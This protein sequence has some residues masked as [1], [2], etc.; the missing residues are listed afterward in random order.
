MG[1]DANIDPPNTDNTKTITR[2][3]CGIVVQIM[4]LILAEMLLANA[5]YTR[6]QRKIFYR[7]VI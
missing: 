7:Y 3:H 4:L 6:S 1:V 5:I 2:K